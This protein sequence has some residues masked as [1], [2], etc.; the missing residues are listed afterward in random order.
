M[1][2]QH[3]PMFRKSHFK[4]GTFS[5][6]CS[7]GLAVTKVPER[8]VNSWDNN[9]RLVKMCD[10]AGLDFML[11]I[12]RWIGY[13]GETNFHYS[14]LETL[15]WA[16]GLLASTERIAAIATMHTAFNHPVVVAKQIATI[17]QIGHGRAGLNIVAGWNQPEYDAMGLTLPD[18]HETRYGYAQEW[19][20]IVRKLWQ[21]REP[22]DWQ[23]Q[24][25][26]LKGVHSDPKPITGIPP[27]V[28]AAGSKQGRGFATRNANFLF[29]PAIDL[30]RSTVEIQELNEQARS[31]GREVEVL[32]FSYVV[33]RPTEEE[34]RAYHAHYAKTNA[35]WAAV[36]N[37]VRLQFAHAQ[38]FPHDLLK[39]IR[40]RM[41]AG[42]GG[43]PLVGTPEQV[44]DGICQLHEAG[45]SGTTLAFV[46]YVDEFPYFRD[47]V[48]PILE[49]RGIRS[50]QT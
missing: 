14:V 27:I 20:D 39:L 50:P 45:F 8:W 29:T 34:A 22:F 6:N 10:A 4:L 18:D 5:A 38:S 26:N 40:D 36:D 32:T 9:L 42:H 30:E 13:G 12:A 15:A 2:E 24:Y 1:P 16:A 41:A 23:G 35:D 47:T 7:S 48:L 44:A 3:N 19:F 31:Q 46:N 11:P 25:F 17:D 28:N 43:F 49:D 33:C 37:L 21:E